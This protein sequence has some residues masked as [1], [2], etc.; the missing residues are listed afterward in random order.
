MAPHNK[1]VRRTTLRQSH[2]LRVL[3]TAIPAPA[4]DG[5]GSNAGRL[6]LGQPAAK[7]STSDSGSYGIIGGQSEAN[8]PS[9]RVFR[10]TRQPIE[11]SHYI[12]NACLAAPSAKHRPSRILLD[13]SGMKGNQ[14]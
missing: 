3:T 7:P 1:S 10:L 13:V 8:G 14:T 2:A 9:R 11:R 5:D 4:I 12:A 6:R